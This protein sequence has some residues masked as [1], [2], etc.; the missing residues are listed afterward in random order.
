MKHTL[1]AKYASNG[2]AAHRQRQ[3]AQV[4]EAVRRMQEKV[5][6]AEIT[7]RLTSKPDL[8]PTTEDYRRAAKASIANFFS[9]QFDKALFDRLKAFNPHPFNIRRPAQYQPISGRSADMIIMDDLVRDDMMDA[10]A[11]AFR[12]FAGLPAVRNDFG[13]IQVNAT[14]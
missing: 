5:R 12:H 13:V 2:L 8:G 11:F 9:T 4:P 6:L 10:T 7:E 1:K 3:I 14:C